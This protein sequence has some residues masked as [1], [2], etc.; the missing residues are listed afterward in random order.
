LCGDREK[1]GGNLNFSPIEQ[2]ARWINWHQHLTPQPPAAHRW[3]ATV[4]K[5]T[6]FGGF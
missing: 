2:R 5:G 4:K 6:N 1:K 3:G